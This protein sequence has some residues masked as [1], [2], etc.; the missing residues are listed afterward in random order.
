MPYRSSF[1]PALSVLDL[2]STETCEI[3]DT[4]RVQYLLRQWLS[5][6]CQGTCF[7]VLE[8]FVPRSAPPLHMD[9]SFGPSVADVSSGGL[10]AHQNHK[11]SVSIWS[12]HPGPPDKHQA[13]LS[14]LCSIGILSADSWMRSEARRLPFAVAC[15]PA[16]IL[17]IIELHN[18]AFSVSSSFSL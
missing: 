2:D 3:R 12:I 17:F 18:M 8:L 7:P 5:Q 14:A 1:L 10:P 11:E 16:Q 15:L 9:S 6:R 4:R 13:M